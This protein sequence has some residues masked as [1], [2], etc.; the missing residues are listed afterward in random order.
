MEEL[1]SDTI[2]FTNIISEVIFLEEVKRV[3]FNRK[4]VLFFLLLLALNLFEM[5]Q[6]FG[7]GIDQEQLSELLDRYRTMSLAEAMEELNAVTEDGTRLMYPYGSAYNQ[8]EYLLGFHENLEQI[9]M[10]AEN[11]S[12]VSIFAGSAFARANIQ[13]TAQ[14]YSGLEGIRLTLGLNEPVEMVMRR[15]LSDWLLGAYMVSAVYAF[16]KERKRGLWNMVCASPNGR[17]HLLTWRFCTI[18]LAAMIAAPVFTGMEII[19]AYGIYGGADELGRMVQSVQMFK[20]LTIPMTIGQLWIFYI[21]LR[22]AGCFFVG[23][24]AWFLLEIIA[25]YRLVGLGWAVF[26]GAE[27]ALYKSMPVE[28]L[29]RQVNLFTYLNPAS[30]VTTYQNL[31][32]FGNPVGHR[33]LVLCAV[34]VFSV[35]SLGIIAIVYQYR[36]PVSGYVWVDRVQDRIRWIFAPLSFHVSLFRH[37]LYKM[38]AIGK[39]AVIL[40]CALG[41]VVLIGNSLRSS[42][43]EDLETILESY[44]RQSKGAVGAETENY[45]SE[46]KE[47][48]ETMSAE[49]D[50][51]MEQYFSGQIDEEKY[52]IRIHAYANIDKQRQALEIY[53]VHLERLLNIEGSYVVPHWVYEQL[54]GEDGKQ[55]GNLIFISAL[56]V[57][58]L[59]AAQIGAERKTGMDRTQDSSPN[60][61]TYLKHRRHRAAWLI[62]TVFSIGVWGIYLKQVIRE[63]GSVPYLQA[64]ACCLSFLEHV[65]ENINLLEYW[66]IL[67]A[68]RTVL[69]GIL[70]SVI[71]LA[72]DR[73]RKKV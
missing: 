55:T 70:S 43:R 48:L 21:L 38:L 33:M 5:S 49:R 3:L 29:L 42:Y 66:L 39:G 45:L 52:N 10:K 41:I 63:Y 17:R 14:D 40:I 11:M 64:P 47:H 61:R 32:L 18:V 28:S 16:L 2:Y 51:L 30:L 34:F 22:T 8:V 73:L 20:E 12:T 31:N 44:Y 23:M 60:G 53:E 71:L 58:L 7:S 6:Y 13:K 59:F 56:A 62:V 25:D 24:L 9:K 69:L 19:C 36:K 37:E 26:A 54:M 72:A 67:V 57:I 1:N 65:P 27:Y 68:V 35:L 15:T 46:R 50:E 4:Q